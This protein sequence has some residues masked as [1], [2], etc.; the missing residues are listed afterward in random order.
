MLFSLLLF[1]SL[2][3][4]DSSGLTRPCIYWTK[5]AG[6]TSKSISNDHVIGI[7]H[8]LSLAEPNHEKLIF[9]FLFD[10]L[11]FDSLEGLKRK[12]AASSDPLDSVFF[13]FVTG[14][15]KINP[16]RNGMEADSF[17]DF[18]ERHQDGTNVVVFKPK[19]K[20]ELLDLFE[21]TSKYESKNGVGYF[22]TATDPKDSPVPQ[23]HFK[24][25]I[26]VET[27]AATEGTTSST[28]VGPVSV[29][30]FTL[31][32][33]LVSL[34]VFVGIYIGNCCLNDIQVPITY[35]HEELP[36]RKEF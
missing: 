26:Y 11:D 7:Q 25:T 33:L 14:S 4:G 6:T 28:Y 18:L 30:P 1:S 29:T 9:G 13:P 17:E 5:S 27:F 16:D 12:I 2:V 22:V 21:K 3:L 31:Q 35:P 34:I 15:F 10:N 24:G 36:I 19:T 32:G 20:E 8:V 23:S